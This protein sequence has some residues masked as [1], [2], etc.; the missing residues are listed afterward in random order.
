MKQKGK[1]GL[2]DKWGC[3]VVRYQYGEVE[4]AVIMVAEAVK[5]KMELIF[6]RLRNT[7]QAK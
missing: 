6:E 3:E 4:I 7:L 5:N 1:W 2:V